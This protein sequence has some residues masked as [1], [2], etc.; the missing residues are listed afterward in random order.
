MQL[1][2]YQPSVEKNSSGISESSAKLEKHD[3][4]YD[5][6]STIA[7]VKEGR[8]IMALQESSINGY[9]ES[10]QSDARSIVKLGSEFEELDRNLSGEI[11]ERF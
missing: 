5:G 11:K 8:A 1:K 10:L 9:K 3:I 6:E 4:T 7:A 2:T